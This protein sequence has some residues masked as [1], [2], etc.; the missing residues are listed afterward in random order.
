MAGGAPRIVFSDMDDTFLAR[1]K[2]VP[3]ENLAAL[4]TL[5]ERGIP[6]VPCTGRPWY[7]VPREVLDH[8]ACRYAV[9]A[10]GTVIVEV[11]DARHARRIH[12][13]PLGK[14]R[15]LAL[16]GRVE[17]LPITFD[18]F[19]EGGIYVDRRRYELVRGFPMIEPE[20]NAYLS[21]RTPL[22]LST[23]EILQRLGGVDRL[24]SFMGT[25]E[26]RR[27]VMVAV[28]EDPTL[29]YT[30]SSD[31]NL[32]ITDARASKGSGVRWLCG[33]LGIS[34]KDAFGFGDSPNDLTMMGAV[35]TGVAVANATPELADA[36]GV[37]L[38]WTS[39]EGGLGRYLSA[40]LD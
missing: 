13:L 24:S 28:G 23:P 5:A 3:A 35:G 31:V 26:L 19:W 1:D 38:P 15:A 34:R 16:Y 18:I 2:S 17:G 12:E 20:R 14:E 40:L 22:D 39:D 33:H 29:A 37:V 9:A 27:Q 36:A 4:D 32:E 6:F 8:L 11:R 25:Q 7:A 30:F 21:G 10:D